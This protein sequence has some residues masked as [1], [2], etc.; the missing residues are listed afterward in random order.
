MKKLM[1][2]VMLLF[3]IGCATTTPMKGKWFSRSNADADQ[4][5]RDKEDCIYRAVM[6]M[7]GT[8]LAFTYQKNVQELAAQCLESRGY[9]FVDDQKLQTSVGTEI[10]LKDL[11]VKRVIKGSPADKEGIKMGDKIIKVNGIPVDSV[12]KLYE[13]RSGKVGDIV[14]YTILRD[15]K[16]MEFSMELVLVSSLGK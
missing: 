13:V 10:G 11:V 12:A 6:M 8:E 9:Y 2:I 14:K 5:N 3:L 15:G 16:E 4:F 1:M 7:K